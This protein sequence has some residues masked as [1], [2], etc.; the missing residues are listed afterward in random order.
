[1]SP[2][3]MFQ[4]T[5]FHLQGGFSGELQERF[6]SKY[7]LWLLNTFMQK[8]LVILYTEWLLTI[9]YTWM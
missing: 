2:L 6:T 4:Q 3:H 5:S 9:L 1:M 8:V 7:T